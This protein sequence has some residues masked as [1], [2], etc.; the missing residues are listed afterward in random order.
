MRIMQQEDCR[1]VLVVAITP[2]TADRGIDLEGISRNVGYLCEA[3]VDFIMPEK[4]TM[5][6]MTGIWTPMGEKIYL[7]QKKLGSYH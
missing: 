3:G 5:R 6:F 7:N 1:N 2:R 4:T